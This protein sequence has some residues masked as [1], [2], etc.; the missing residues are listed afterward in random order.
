MP[1]VDWAGLDGFEYLL[2]TQSSSV[3]QSLMI[4]HNDATTHHHE[5]TLS[6]YLWPAC[7]SGGCIYE[8]LHS[9]VGIR[10]STRSRFV[11]QR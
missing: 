1:S 7:H 3:M 4:A 8:L 6:V 5:H 11:R 9:C 10:G 2:I